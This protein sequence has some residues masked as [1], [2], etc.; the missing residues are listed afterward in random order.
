MHDPRNTDT[1]EN[2]LHENLAQLPDMNAIEFSVTGHT[3][4]SLLYN[5]ALIRTVN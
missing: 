3:V 1:G 4:S 2:E 5:R